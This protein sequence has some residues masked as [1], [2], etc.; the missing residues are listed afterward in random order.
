MECRIRHP[1]GAGL[2]AGW[3][4]DMANKH[5]TMKPRG[6][7]IRN[8]EETLQIEQYWIWLTGQSHAYRRRTTSTSRNWPIYSSN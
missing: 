5:K 6:E 8:A 7:L 4:S 2:A 3:R 1:K